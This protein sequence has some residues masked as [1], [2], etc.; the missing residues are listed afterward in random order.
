MRSK[1]QG[2]SKGAGLARGCCRAR[3]APPLRLVVVAVLTSAAARARGQC[4]CWRPRTTSDDGIRAPGRGSPC[5]QS[6]GSRSVGA[7]EIALQRASFLSS[8]TQPVQMFEPAVPQAVRIATCDDPDK[9]DRRFLFT[10]A[11]AAR[12]GGRHMQV[13][14]L[15]ARLL[16]VAAQQA[17]QI[18]HNHWARRIC[19]RC[20]RS[21]RSS[22]APG[23][24]QQNSHRRDHFRAK[25]QHDV[26]CT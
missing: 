5:M 6:S 16:A 26:L 2:V 20:R 19:R 15:D 7:T 12:R 8:A 13:L 10:A 1:L 21:Q 17:H 3:R 23:T 11:P 18:Q 4:R 24:K 25:S 9:K 22:N 14:L